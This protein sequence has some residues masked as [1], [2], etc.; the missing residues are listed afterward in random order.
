MNSRGGM[1]TETV[2][3]LRGVS[4]EIPASMKIENPQ[5]FSSL[6][7]Q[8]PNSRIAPS[9][10]PMEEPTT[11][12]GMLFLPPTMNTVQDAFSIDDFEGDMELERPSEEDINSE[13]ASKIHQGI[14]KMKSLPYKPPKFS[15]KKH[16]RTAYYAKRR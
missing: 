5:P 15:I 7:S 2:F 1:N 13:N 14:M 10:K 12:M 9:I 16:L 8:E 4:G 3:H 11:N 6:F